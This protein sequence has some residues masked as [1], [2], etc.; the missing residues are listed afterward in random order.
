MGWWVGWNIAAQR[1]ELDRDVG[2]D[3]GVVSNLRACFFYGREERG[4]TR[5]S[6]VTLGGRYFGNLA[7]SA[8]KHRLLAA[9]TR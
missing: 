4:F 9:D 2:P 1:G 5:V 6:H 7:R 3:P 8:G